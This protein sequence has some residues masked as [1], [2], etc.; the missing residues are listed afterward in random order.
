MKTDTNITPSLTQIILN[1]LDQQQAEEIVQVS[2][3]GKSLIADD[4]IVANGRSSRHIMALASYIDDAVW[5][6]SHFHCRIEGKT[7][8]EWVL[9]DAGDVIVHLFKPD[10]RSFYKIE[11]LWSEELLKNRA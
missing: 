4:M 6:A 11:Q 9:I 2:L 1:V 10:V 8:G 3:I 5:Q 7:T